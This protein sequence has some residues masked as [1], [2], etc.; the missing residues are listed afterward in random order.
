[1]HSIVDLRNSFLAYLEKNTIIKEPQNLYN[2][3]NYILNLEGKRLRPILT[4]MAA[5][6]FDC[7]FEKA[8]PA[9][10][11]VEIFHNFTLVHDDI[12]D[13]APLRRGKATVHHKWNLN[14]GILSG[15]VMLIISYQ[16]FD[17]YEPKTFKKLAKLLS[18]TAIEVCEGQQL[19]VDFE[20]RSDVSIEEYIQMI[21]YKTAVLVGAAMKMGAIVA[22]ADKSD[23]KLIYDFGLYLGIAFQLQDDYLDVFGDAASFGKQIAGDIIENKKTYL[24]IKAL[25]L[26]DKTD[27]QELLQLFSEK[28]KDNSSK[29]E[30]VVAIYKKYGS[31]VATQVEI[32]NYTNRAFEVL[33]QIN[34]SKNNKAILRSFGENLMNR[35]F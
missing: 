20:T 34:L 29:I 4:L 3:A 14:T 24:F 23:R 6:L 18:K 28:L 13:E 10:A 26:A 15:D 16:Y 11:A 5:E 21:T 22:K 27:R 17:I 9:A 31:D 25:E 1:M 19:D 32:Q 30:K 8:L 33:D 7:E 2:P 12:M 35:K